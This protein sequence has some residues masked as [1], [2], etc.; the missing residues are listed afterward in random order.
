MA[1]KWIPGVVGASLLALCAAPLCAAD[2]VTIPAG[3]L[4]SV[5]SGGSSKNLP[6]SV[7]RF[8]MRS[9]PVT[10]AEF[11]AFT[12][13]HPEWQRGAAPAVFADGSYLY[14]YGDPAQR[15][16]DAQ[17]PVTSVSWFAAQAYCESEQARLPTWYEWEYVAAADA[18][19]ADARHKP[20][21][22]ARILAWYSQASSK[23]P[24]LVGGAPNFYGARDLHG[25]IWEWVDDFGAL[26]VSADSRNQGDPEQLQYCGAGAISL[27][28]RDNYAIL[29]RIALLSSLNAADT[30]NSLGFR[31][32]KPLGEK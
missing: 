7:A 22:R 27:Q 18:T 6:V 9:T 26:L 11:F 32:A 3:S 12:E 23:A 19:E 4:T 28:D 1:G 10:V 14:A 25:L 31:C 20:L 15:R 30:T 5:L 17:R 13:R 21:W 29:M 16:A 24:A 8:A 2:Y